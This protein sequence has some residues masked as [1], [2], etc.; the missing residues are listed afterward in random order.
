MKKL[1][2]VITFNLFLCLAT[3]AQLNTPINVIQGDSGVSLKANSPVTTRGIV[4]A[5]VKKGFFIQTPDS[6][7][8]KSSK[9]SEG[10]F[11]FTNDEK[12][13]VVVGDL[14]DVSG[15][16][17]EY[18]PRAERF[19]LPLTQITRP[20][21]NVVSKGNSL[22]APIVLT[23]VDLDPKGK[24]D[25]M[26]RYEGMRVK[27]NSLTVTA[28]TGGR[29]DDKKGINF[30]N[31]LFFGVL[32]GTQRPMKEAGLDM[33]D[34]L[35]DN[36]PKNIWAFDMNPENLRFDSVSQID[37][38]QIHVAA[39]ETLKNVVGV[40]DYA[41]RSYTILVDSD[42]Q[43]TIE[44]KRVAVP[45]PAAK[46]REITVASFNLENLFDDEI[47]SDNVDK[48][49]VTPKEVFN[50]RLNKMSLAIRN[51]LSMPD[52][53]GVIEVENLK[54][55]TKLADKINADAVA[56]NQPNPNYIPYL[57]EGN[58]VRGIDVGYLVK[59]K[60]KVLETKQIGKDVKPDIQANSKEM[61]FDRPSLLLRAEAIDS[62]TN[63][64]FQFTTIVVHLKS[65]GGINDEKDGKRVQNK[66][67]Q[68][69]EW[70]ANFV[71]ERGKTN[72]NERIILCGDFN[73]FQF[74]DGYN[75][76]MGTLIGKAD[77]NVLVPSKADY[78]T[79]L[80][81]LIYSLPAK[82]RYSYVFGGNAQAIDHILISANMLKNVVDFRYAR[83][84][85]DFPAVYY[86][87]YNRPERVSDH[88]APIVYL[89]FDERK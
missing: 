42:N 71:A 63:K 87:N 50:G 11:V 69:A 18:K 2:S 44:N 86:N 61:L 81:N 3:F 17:F 47:N 76:M 53:L 79:N 85:T 75:D 73:A 24:L 15:T 14:V 49:Q 1:I 38:K 20:R 31:G 33:L 6:E 74:P 30:T 66:K 4:T 16:V 60:I 45:V 27:I 29:V 9:T 55:L 88:D 41:F 36:L 21:V 72:S 89:S 43:P 5:I 8:D 70:L 25:Q 23:A 58:D 48:E 64:P 68:Q 77:P 10:I 62:K 19:A 57:E 32:T 83:F 34:V 67:R 26:E 52:V 12:I 35:G 39:G 46:E 54:V 80:G 78:K 22:P 82:D 51:I 7:I 56:N 65:Y 84:D 37:R 59:S 13:N 28:P 40:V